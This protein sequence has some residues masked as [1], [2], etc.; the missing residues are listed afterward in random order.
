[1]NKFNLS[2][3]LVVVCVALLFSACGNKTGKSQGPDDSLTGNRIVETGELAAI[4]SR[5]FVMP[6]YGRH[7]YMMKIIGILKHGTEVKK[8]DSVIQLDP[9]DIKKYI[10]ERESRLE[11]QLA[12]LEKL[13]VD[14]QNR[15]QELDSRLK[16]ET[17]SYNLK[18]LELERIRMEQLQN[19]IKN[20]Y[21]LL[22]ALTIRTPIS[23]IF[24]VAEN[25]RT[26]EM[27]KIGDEIFVGNNL[28]N[29]PDLTWMKVNTAVNETDYFKLKTGQKVIVRLDALPALTFEGEVSYLGKLC[30]PKNNNSRQKVFEV[31]V[32]ISESDE[33]LKPGMTVSCEFLEE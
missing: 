11:T 29:V 3:S 31:E 19:E 32:R 2:A 16:N 21:D 23:G 14:Q 24:Q 22:P 4:D 9:T 33:R 20:A 6:R 5:S 13:H 26:K 30:Q 17:A 25:R 1:M 27:V 18:K 15:I 10:I 7:W 8:G 12:V 28:G